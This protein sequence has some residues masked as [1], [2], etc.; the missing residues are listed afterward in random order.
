MGAL[1]LATASFGE[2]F[3]QR[4]QILPTI[5][6][7]L[8]IWRYDPCREHR[9]RDF[10]GAGDG[11]SLL[12]QAHLRIVVEFPPFPLLLPSIP[13]WLFQLFAPP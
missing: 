1:P 8:E 5:S 10:D 13:S 4:G 3:G 6:S 2:V 7:D 12:G 9:Q 11:T